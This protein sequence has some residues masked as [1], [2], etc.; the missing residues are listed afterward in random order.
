MVSSLLER[1]PLPKTSLFSEPS[2][3]L[4]PSNSSRDSLQEAK[5]PRLIPNSTFGLPA[6][7]VMPTAILAGDSAVEMG[8]LV[9]AD[10]FRP[11]GA[12]G[13]TIDHDVRLER[14]VP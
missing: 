6:V 4:H 8:V 14:V 12:D 2:H 13:R 7:L 11:G 5:I 9:A 10:G 1:H 3:P